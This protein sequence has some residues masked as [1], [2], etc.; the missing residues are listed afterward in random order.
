MHPQHEVLLITE[1]LKYQ[2]RFFIYDLYKRTGGKSL[3][4]NYSSG[5][6]RNLWQRLKVLSKEFLILNSLPG[7]KENQM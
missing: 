5:T 3:T 4:G 7:K 1:F 2:R 6:S